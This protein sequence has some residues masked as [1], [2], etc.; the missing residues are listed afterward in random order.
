MTPEEQ[1]KE[2][3]RILAMSDEEILADAVQ[4]YGSEKAA[5]A[6][7]DYMGRWIREM[8]K[9][10]QAR[11]EALEAIIGWRERDWPEGFDRRTAE[12]FADYARTLME[13]TE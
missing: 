4:E 6:I 11:R 3:E 1:D 9:A 10:S 12:M 8:V 7:A 13:K 2:V 5:R